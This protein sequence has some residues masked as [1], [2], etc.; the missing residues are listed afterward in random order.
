MPQF[1]GRILKNSAVERSALMFP[2]PRTLAFPPAGSSNVLLYRKAKPT[3]ASFAVLHFPVKN[4]DELAKR[5]VR[6]E[7]YHEPDFT[8]LI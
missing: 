6:F 8:S 7:H 1:F 2:S 3:T 5:G 4:V